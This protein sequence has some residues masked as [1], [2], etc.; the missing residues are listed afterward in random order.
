MAALT[1]AEQADGG[2]GGESIA[3]K[4]VV[5]GEDQRPKSPAERLALTGEP[6]EKAVKCLAEAVY[7]ESRGEPVRGQITPSRKSS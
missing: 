4:G 5:T 6:L 2:K 1:P 3:N 7:F